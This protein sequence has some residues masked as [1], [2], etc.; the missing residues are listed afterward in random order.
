MT[1]AIR[2]LTEIPGASVQDLGR[3]GYLGMGVARG[4]AMDRLAIHE[5]A[6]LLGQSSD[7]AALEFSGAGGRLQVL[8]GALHVA[9]TGAQMSVTLDGVAL[10]HAT[11]GRAE[12]GTVIE[13]SGARAGVYGYL[14]VDGGFATPAV[15]GARAT[16]QASGMGQ[17]AKM[18]QVLP[19]GP[20]HE[21]EPGLTL[22]PAPRLSG[23]LVRLVRSYQTDHFSAQQRERLV[24][25]DFIRAA[26]GNR[27][28]V[29]LEGGRFAAEGALQ[30]LSDIIVPGDVQMTGDG[31]PFILLADCQT[32]G[33]YPRI[34]T[35]LP[36][37]I[38]VVAQA[39]PG[40]ALRMQWVS[41]ADGVIAESKAAQYIADLSAKVHTRLRAAQDL[42]DLLS[43]QL[44]SGAITGWD[45]EERSR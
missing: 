38:P 10:P 27:M 34:G 20:A 2:A 13:I 3:S 33:G 37:D 40:T 17:Q 30:V 19:L 43:Y 32:T 44:I 8:G 4:G 29:R 36:C 45:E 22:D 35:V 31:A 1:R 42:Q 15:L 28:G 5:G 12:Q 16:H 26:Q 39:G 11:T 6:A 18:G 21:R 23:G 14:H 7:H 25:T 24:H 41:L 9:I